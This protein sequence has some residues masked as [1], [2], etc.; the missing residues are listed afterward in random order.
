VMMSSAAKQTFE[1]KPLTISNQPSI[2]N[3]KP[4][5]TYPSILRYRIFVTARRMFVSKHSGKRGKVLAVH[6]NCNGRS[7]HVAAHSPGPSSHSL[8]TAR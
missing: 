5:V 6:P 7:F 3:S 1:A 8:K 2:K 4:A